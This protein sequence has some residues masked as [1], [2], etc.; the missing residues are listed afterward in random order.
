M[1]K[2]EQVTAFLNEARTWTGT[3][4]LSGACVKG[5]GVDCVRFLAQ[6]A[7]NAGVVDVVEIRNGYSTVVPEGSEYVDRLLQ[8]ADEI[9][10]AEVLPGDC[11]LARTAH[12]WMHSA[13]IISW[14]DAVI[15]ATERRG[16]VVTPGNED[17]L[18]GKPLRFFRLRG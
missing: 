13:I 7:V 3:P 16:V 12:G 6:A 11:L 2:P 4:Y 17:V 18:R 15:H 10:E 14:P 1:L 8:Y 5:G 9:T